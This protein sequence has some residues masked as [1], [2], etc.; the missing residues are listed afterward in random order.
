MNDRQQDQE[1]LVDK[2]EPPPVLYIQLVYKPQLKNIF[3]YGQLGQL[4]QLGQPGQPGQPGQLT[5]HDTF[6]LKKG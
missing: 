6:W 5:V 3:L 4:G 1:G 2:A